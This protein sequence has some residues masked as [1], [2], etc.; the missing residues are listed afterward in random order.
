MFP[1]SIVSGQTAATLWLLAGLLIG[2]LIGSLTRLLINQIINCER[3]LL[4]NLV[5]VAPSEYLPEGP[6]F[7]EP[8]I[9]KLVN[10]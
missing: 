10:T 8:A 1:R 9:V 6:D 2:S 7:S 3:A 4:K 5:I